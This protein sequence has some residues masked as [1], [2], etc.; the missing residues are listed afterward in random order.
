MRPETG[1][2]VDHPDQLARPR[3]V[4]RRRRARPRMHSLD[5]MLSRED[6]HGMIERQR[7]AHGIRSASL[8]DH[9]APS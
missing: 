6:L 5:H 9:A 4:D 7:G 3:I 2:Q 1:R 8:S